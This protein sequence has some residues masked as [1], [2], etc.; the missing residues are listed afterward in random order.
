MARHRRSAGVGPS[1]L[2]FA[3]AGPLTS[4]RRARGPARTRTVSML[5]AGALAGG[6][7]IAAATL[8]WWHTAPLPQPRRAPHDD[9]TEG[10]GAR[11]VGPVSAPAERG[12]PAVAVVPAPRAA[13]P[14]S[15]PALAHAS[16]R[17]RA[18]APSAFRPASSASGSAAPRVEHGEVSFD[19][20]PGVRRSEAEPALP[21]VDE[22]DEHLVSVAVRLDHPASGRSGRHVLLRWENDGPGSAPVDLRVHD[23][24]LV[25]H[26]GDGHPSGP[27]TFTQDLGRA[28]EGEWTHLAVRVRFS[29]NPEKGR[30][31]V[32]RDGR[33]VVKDH[34]PR[35]GTLYPGQQ[36]YLKAGLRREAGTSH[37]ARA[38]M[39][40][41]H[42]S[43]VHHGE[44][45]PS[46]STHHDGHSRSSGAHQSSSHGQFGARHSRS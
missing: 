36:S 46:G 39:R 31:S 21:A 38:T 24:R 8:P 17:W 15:I 4:H 10:P 32:R 13:E 3:V 33:T 26:G 29:A 20:A 22:G 12:S 34:H 6:A 14:S 11:P 27:R 18:H 35:G 25:L 5:T 44:S 9:H 45:R 28:P 30:V 40:N 1:A 16:T 42:V 7:A 19:L 41:W 37:A 43:G 2:A 23:G